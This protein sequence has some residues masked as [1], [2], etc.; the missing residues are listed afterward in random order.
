MHIYIFRYVFQKYISHIIITSTRML[1]INSY[2]L[3]AS[4]LSDSCCK[5]FHSFFRFYMDL[6]RDC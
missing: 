2:F 1:Y 3:H 6:L 4:E 5:L